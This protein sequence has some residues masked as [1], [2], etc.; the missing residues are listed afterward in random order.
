MSPQMQIDHL[1]S[2]INEIGN[3]ID[4]IKQSWVQKQNKNVQLL[5]QRTKQINELSKIRTCEYFSR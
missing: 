3:E 4:S 2:K 1:R 5:H